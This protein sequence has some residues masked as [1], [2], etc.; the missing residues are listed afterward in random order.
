MVRISGMKN[1]ET[2]VFRK[3]ELMKHVHQR[4]Q[5]RWSK[6]CTRAS[7]VQE[8]PLHSP[9]PAGLD[10]IDKHRPARSKVKLALPSHSYKLGGADNLQFHWHSLFK[11]LIQIPKS[12]REIHTPPGLPL[13]GNT[14]TKPKLD[15][16]KLYFRL[17]QYWSFFCGMRKRLFKWLGQR[18]VEHGGV[19][20]SFLLQVVGG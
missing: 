10:Q 7:G 11:R 15:S 3:S 2:L 5:F 6:L 16:E 9:S 13:A 17:I 20:I 4:C 8:S 12:R 19:N 18:V 14:K 1:R